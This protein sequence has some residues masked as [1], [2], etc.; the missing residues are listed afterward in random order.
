MEKYQKIRILGQGACSKVFLVQDDETGEHWVV[1]QIEATLSGQERDRALQEAALLHAHRHPGIVGYR[2]AFI[3]R[4][5]YICLIMEYADGGDL[6]EFL[7]THRFR[8]GTLFPELQVLHWFAQL[9]TALR[10][11]HER[12]VL[13]RDIKARNIFLRG[14]GKVIQLG[15][16]GISTV[17]ESA[18]GSVSSAIGT[19]CYASPE[20]MRRRPYGASADIWSLGVVIYELC[21]LRRPFE[22]ETLPELVEQIVGGQYHQ[23]DPHS[24]SQDLRH[25]VD[26][27]LAQE[28]GDRPL[29]GD[30]L[31]L[32]FLREVQRQVPEECGAERNV[33]GGLETL[34]LEAPTAQA[35]SPS[36]LE[37]G[38]RVCGPPAGLRLDGPDPQVP[39]VVLP[40]EGD[41]QSVPTQDPISPKNAW[42]AAGIANPHQSQNEGTRPRLGVALLHGARRL[43][44]LEC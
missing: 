36:P 17:L 44:G 15:D 28:A 30:L 29:A 16:F 25:T 9:L 11:L 21:A 18:G 22:A 23:L 7:Q 10:F 34:V 1:K 13:H 2:E 5:G 12:Y 40:D 8:G 4:S 14:Q 42:E 32:P 19:P 6:H 37:Q 31:E 3:T 41:A 39:Q 24:F 27:M 26:R 20:R 38:K 35:Q 33:S 43:F